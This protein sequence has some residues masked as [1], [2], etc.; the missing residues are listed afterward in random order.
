M[1]SLG[2]LV[3]PKHLFHVLAS[4]IASVVSSSHPGL[5]LAFLVVRYI[6]SSDTAGVWRRKA[7]AGGLS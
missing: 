4:S 3:A 1:K 6:A 7:V 5:D 2:S